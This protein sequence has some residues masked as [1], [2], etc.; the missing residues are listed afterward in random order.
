ML[1][2]RSRPDSSP[3]YRDYRARRLRWTFA[4]FGLFGV[5]WAGNFLVVSRQP[6]RYHP[7]VNQQSC[8]GSAPQHGPHGTARSPWREAGR[9]ANVWLLC[10]IIMLSSFNSYFFFSWYSPYLQE[11]RA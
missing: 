7:A 8:N 4:I 9:N 6:R 3:R 5:A 11:A 1:A 2:G 10:A